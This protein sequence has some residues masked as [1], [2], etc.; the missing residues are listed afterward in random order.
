MKPWKAA[1]GAAGWPRASSTALRRGGERVVD[2]AEEPPLVERLD[3]EVE[4][5][6]AH[7]LDRAVDRAVGGDDDDAGLGRL[8]AELAQELEPVAVGKLQVEEHQLRHASVRTRPRLG[9]IEGAG[10][11]VAGAGQHRLVE[12]R[13]ATPCPRRGAAARSPPRPHVTDRRARQ[14]STAASISAMQRRTSTSTFAALVG[15]R[16]RVDRPRAGLQPHRA[17]RRR[18]PRSGCARPS[19]SARGRGPAAPRRVRAARRA[20]RRSPCRGARPSC[21]RRSPRHSASKVAMSMT[22]PSPSAD[23]S[24]ARRRPRAAGERAT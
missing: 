15:V 11:A 21:R 10:D 18:R 2:G 19:G 7:R 14:K 24:R 13:R 6:G 20:G 4:G 9:E 3:Q 1:G 23:D 8:A 5:P 12:H 22:G 16:R 17:R